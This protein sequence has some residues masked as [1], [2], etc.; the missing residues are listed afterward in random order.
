MAKLIGYSERGMVNAL[1]ADLLNEDSKVIE[2]I[3]ELFQFPLVEQSPSFVDIQ[4]TIIIVEQSFSNF[5]SADLI[6]LLTHQDGRKQSLFIEAKVH[7]DK[8]RGRQIHQRWEFFTKFVQ[9]EF[10]GSKGTSALFSQLYRKNQL[11]RHLQNPEEILMAD[12]VS[13][14]WKLGKNRVVNRA[15]KLI[16]PYID[17]SWM[18]ALLPESAESVDEFYRNTI[19][20]FSVCEPVN[21]PG[22]DSCRWGYVTWKDI[23][24]HCKAEPKAF[25]ST[26]AAFDWNR[27]Q[28]YCGW[29]A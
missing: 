16:R 14:H 2:G 28:V 21:L 26:L 27:E 11:V 29:D 17:N 25:Q 15:A 6:F 9:G 12:S 18:V 13:K 5:G 1:S 24:N 22:W 20:K 3:L 8:K 4:N 10:K 23:E 7:S 19:G